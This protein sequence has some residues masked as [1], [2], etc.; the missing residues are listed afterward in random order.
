MYAFHIRR[1]PF[2]DDKDCLKDIELAIKLNYPKQ[3]HCKIYLRAVQCYLKLGK[4]DLAE[5]TLSK[6]HRMMNN[7]DYIVPSMKGAQRTIRII[8]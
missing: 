2:D 7:P 3:L 4:R 1:I 6:I 5:E 8:K